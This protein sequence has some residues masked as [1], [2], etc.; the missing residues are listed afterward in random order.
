MANDGKTVRLKLTINPAQNGDPDY[1]LDNGKSALRCGD[2]AYGLIENIDG[3]HTLTFGHPAHAHALFGITIGD[4]LRFPDQDIRCSI[5]G[6]TEQVYTD[7]EVTGY[8][9]V[10]MGVVPTA[11][12]VH[13]FP[14]NPG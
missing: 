4:R 3:L 5:K 8:F 12:T 6:Y 2:G 9:R 14:V 7:L 13:L 10:A 1:V 11:H